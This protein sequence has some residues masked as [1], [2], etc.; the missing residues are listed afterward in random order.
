M[1]L[2][3]PQHGEVQFGMYSTMKHNIV[4]YQDHVHDTHACTYTCTHTHMYGTLPSIHTVTH[5][6]LHLHTNTHTHTHTHTHIHTQ[7]HTNTHTHTLYNHKYYTTMAI[8]NHQM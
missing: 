2:H 4:F 5:L 1:R 8:L 6:H 7:T 3:F